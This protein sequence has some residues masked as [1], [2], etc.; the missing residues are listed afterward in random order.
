MS[1]LFMQSDRARQF[2]IRQTPLDF[3]LAAVPQVFGDIDRAIYSVP[4]NRR[5][6]SGW[7]SPTFALALNWI[8]S[9]TSLSRPPTR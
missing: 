1:R 8:G 5:N 9:L 3:E 4:P 7:K 6:A 2:M